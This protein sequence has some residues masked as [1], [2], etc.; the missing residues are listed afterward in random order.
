MSIK[1]HR[2]LWGSAAIVAML[3]GAIVV[4]MYQSKLVAAYVPLPVWK[5]L[6]RN[7][8]FSE[9]TVCDYDNPSL[10]TYIANLVRHNPDQYFP[11]IV[12][13][14]MHED[15]TVS[16]DKMIYYLYLGKI[17]R[18][19]IDA[20]QRKDQVA[21]DVIAAN[22]LKSRNTENIIEYFYFLY[23]VEYRSGEINKKIA[24]YYT[25]NSGDIDTDVDFLLTMYLE[26]KGGQ[27][28]H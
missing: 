22:A 15:V 2:A 14:I 5:W 12:K 16:T 4:A 3:L 11:I 8:L 6:V 17:E 23:R 24:Q 19:Y 20:I 13:R 10:N 18:S 1:V 28:P 7:S 9:R 21:L 27:A 26:D 25:E